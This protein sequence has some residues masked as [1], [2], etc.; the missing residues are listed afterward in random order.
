VP[1]ERRA[2]HLREHASD[3]FVATADELERTRTDAFGCR[4]H[5]CGEARDRRHVLG[6]RA[7][8]ALLSPAVQERFERERAAHEQRPGALRAAELVRGDRHSVDGDPRPHTV[9]ERDRERRRGLHRIR[10]HEGTAG[11]REGGEPG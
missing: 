7:K 2:R 10:V 3:E 5:G 6:A 4:T 8:L 11:P 1:G 9:T